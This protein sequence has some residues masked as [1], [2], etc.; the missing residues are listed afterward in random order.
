MKLL[1]SSIISETSFCFISSLPLD[2]SDS[3]QVC[4][5]DGKK[6]IL[7]NCCKKNEPKLLRGCLVPLSS[8]KKLGFDPSFCIME[9]NTMQN[10]WQKGGYS[11]FWIVASSSQKKPKRAPRGPHDVNKFC[12]LDGTK[13]NPE[14]FGIL[15][16][17]ISK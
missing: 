14:N 2:S 11:P 5:V 3:I 12:I 10:F 17:I 9:L 4:K 6:S 15:H 1:L 13:H 8:Q 16:S 7:H